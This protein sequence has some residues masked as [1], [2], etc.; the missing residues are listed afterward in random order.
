MRDFIG[1]REGAQSNASHNAMDPKKA[2][3][4][5]M[6]AKTKNHYLLALKTFSRW[7]VKRGRMA[8]NPFQFVEP[9][10]VAGDVQRA[11]RDLTPDEA[12]ALL[13]AVPA[14]LSACLQDSIGDGLAAGRIG[15]TA[16][17]RHAVGLAAT[18]H[19]TAVPKPRRP[20]GQICCPCAGIWSK[21]MKQVVAK[22]A[23]LNGVPSRSS[24]RE[25]IGGGSRMRESI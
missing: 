14:E 25:C 3:V 6:S 7:C 19:P 20:V 2:K 1:W 8:D 18:I 10:D 24:D 9:L 13:A 15:R 4:E 22:Q 16:M 12:I 5:A 23:T 11:R 21:L 17:G